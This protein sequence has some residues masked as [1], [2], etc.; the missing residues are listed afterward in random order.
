MSFKENSVVFI[1]Y[2]LT[3]Q[4]NLNKSD[5]VNFNF[6]LNSLYIKNVLILQ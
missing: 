6:V 1:L 2:L 5:F 3:I 4:I